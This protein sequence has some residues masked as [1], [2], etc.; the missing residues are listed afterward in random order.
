MP[1]RLGRA[2]EHVG[3]LVERLAEDVMQHERDPLR[4]AERLE[5]YEQGDA[6]LIALGDEVG[7]VG[8]SGDRLVPPGFDLP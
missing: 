2:F 7:G 4:R 3:D 5:Q 6:H 1:C 8:F